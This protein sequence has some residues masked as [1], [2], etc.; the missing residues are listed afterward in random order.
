MYAKLRPLGHFVRHFVEMC[1]VMC[2]GLGVLDLTFFGIMGMIGYSDPLVE[3]PEVS[4]LVIALNMAVPMVAWMRFRHHEWAPIWEMSGAMFVE[5]IV[6]IS[7]FWL[8]LVPAGRSLFSLQHVLMMPAML[9]P[10]LFR[11]DLYTGR[12]GHAAARPET[13]LSKAMVSQ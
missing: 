9:I 3:L 11:L 5:A 2:I 6:L 13:A 8:G 10:M 7:V 1:A 4:T 12:V